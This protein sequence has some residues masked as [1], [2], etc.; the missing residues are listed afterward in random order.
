MVSVCKGVPGQ[1]IGEERVQ[2]GTL[3]LLLPLFEP[4]FVCLFE[5]LQA[6]FVVCFLHKA[7]I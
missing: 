6:Y 2:E 4:L 3:L 5:C 1:A 7:Q